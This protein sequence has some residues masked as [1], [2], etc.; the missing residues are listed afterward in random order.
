MIV[1]IKS[2]KSGGKDTAGNYLCQNHNFIKYGFADP[3]KKGIQQMFGFSDDQL[4]GDKKEIVDPFWGVLPREILQYAGTELFQFELPK[5]IPNFNKIGRSIWVKAFEKWY[6]NHMEYGSGQNVAIID[7]RF[8]HEAKKIK[9]L[10]GVILEI[11][12]DTLLDDYS[13]HASEVEL[14]QIVP[15]HIIENNSSLEYLYKNIDIFM[16]KYAFLNLQHI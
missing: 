16:K 9:E 8:L 5:L 2:R 1:G 12:R 6:Y 3:L 14:S 7:L 4:W 13:Y 10:G 11:K 15:D